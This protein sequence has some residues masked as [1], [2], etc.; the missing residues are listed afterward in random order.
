MP[1]SSEHSAKELGSRSARQ[2]LPIQV[3]PYFTH[4]QGGLSLGYRRGKRGGTWIAR[5]HDDNGY[6]FSPL[7]KA[8]DLSEKV[9][10]SFQAAQDAARQ[11]LEALAHQDASEPVP[12]PHTVEQVMAQYVTERENVKRKALKATR[13]AINAHIL[14][15]L[16]AIQVAALTKRDVQQWFTSLA[17]TAPRQRTGFVKIKV[18]VE[19]TVNGVRVQRLRDRAT[20]VPL[21]QSYR[22]HVTNDADALRKRQATANRILTVLKAAL[23]FAHDRE[24]VTSKDAWVNVKPFRQVDQ[25]KVRFMSSAEVSALLTA[26]DDDFKVLVRAAL[27]TGCRYG[28]LAHLRVKHFDSKQEQVFIAESKNGESRHVELNKEG[29]DLFQALA[30]N[31]SAEDR[32]FLRS[33]GSAWKPSEQKRYID[34]ACKAAK[35]ERVTFHILRHTYASHLVMA[36]VPLLTVAHQLGHKD[37]R[38]TAKH[39]AHLSRQHVRDSIRQHLPAFGV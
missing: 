11:W 2:R 13:T 35:V 16:G 27:L 15:Q 8:N 24:L 9:G 22:E 30:A 34:R 36:G 7:G 25:A 14:P 10:V 19:H 32:M 12:E 26:S 6:R 21:P 1:R 28:E 31:R 4:V 18:M 20:D 17:T 37:T 3:H 33:N 23:N 29:I 39:Y 38:I 5:V